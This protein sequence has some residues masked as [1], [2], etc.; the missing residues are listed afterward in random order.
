MLNH[1]RNIWRKELTDTIRDRKALTQAIMVPLLI[2]IL[3]AVMN[4][5]LGSLLEA[6]AEKPI[7]IP[8]Q[9]IEN[10]GEGFIAAL[11]GFD[12]SLEPFDGD[13][14]PMIAAGE[15]AAG[16]IIPPGFDSSIANEQAAGLTLLTNDT[17]GGIFGGSFSV[18]RLELALTT[19]SQAITVNRLQEQDI[20]PGILAPITLDTQ[21]LAT[22]AQRAGVFASLMLPML[23]SL[24]AAQG[25]MFIAIDVTAGEKERGTLEAL[26]V[27]P[28]GDVEI[29]LGKL[30]AVFTLTAVPITLTLLG[31]WTF[32][33]ILPETMTDG[34]VL[35]FA[36]II[37]AILITLPLALFLNVLLMIIS[38]RT[39]AFKDAQ[40][41]VTPVIMGAMSISMAAAFVPPSDT[42]MFL[43]PL[44]GTSAVVGVLA[45][46]GVVPAGAVLLSVAGSIVAAAVGIVFA[47]R[48]FNREWLLY[49]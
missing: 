31:F 14:R 19:Y 5:L 15:Q 9:G 47:L 28:A 1:M 36:L 38:I 22:P 23:V 24:I 10:A 25:G 16:L 37:K 11:A 27:T 20:D 26:L 7:T 33:S 35:P 42:I 18:G 30:A 44:Y 43:I 4:P 48:L 41:S 21:D 45:V 6:R 39:K 40:S 8:V 13:M 12:I 34:A 29:L 2:G 17:S 49:N 32:S 3:Y 46:G